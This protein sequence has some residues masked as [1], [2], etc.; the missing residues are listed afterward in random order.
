MELQNNIGTI[1]EKLAILSTEIRLRGKFNMLDINV[2]AESFFADLLN[3]IFGYQLKNINLFEQNAKAIDLID[4]ENKIIV[5]VSSDNSKEKIQTSLRGI[6][7][8]Y[9][10][11]NYH[12]IFISISE[13]VTKLKEKSFEIPKGI[14]FNPK[15]DCFDNKT[16]ITHIESKGTE[17][18]KKVSEYL[19][20]TVVYTERNSAAPV[21]V[22]PFED[23]NN[24][25]ARDTAVVK[26]YSIVKENRVTN[27]YGFGGSGKTSLIN[28]FVKKYGNE[29]N[30]KVYIAV[31]NS[32]REDFIKKIN[33]TIRIEEKKEPLSKDTE[34]I[35][36]RTITF[37]ENNYKSEKKSTHYRHKQCTRR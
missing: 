22:F 15:N 30:Q 35:F 11:E 16:L 25:I 6:K 12:F 3:L 36:K 19:N 34:D 1:H 17:C 20:K 21:F 32:I 26:L 28:L 29:F 33:A 5:Q 10:K 2:I 7:E 9:K 14:I 24:L 37:L 8:E 31:N 27:L 18:I 23:A 4:T 13:V